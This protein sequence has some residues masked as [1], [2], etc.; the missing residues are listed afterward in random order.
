MDCESLTRTQGAT[1]Q[2]M[3]CEYLTATHRATQQSMDGGSL[4]AT[5][6]DMQQSVHCESLTP[7]QGA[8]Q[9]IIG[10]VSSTAQHSQRGTKSEL[11]ASTMPSRRPKS[12]PKA[13]SAL[14]SRWSPTTRNKMTIGCLSHAFSGAQKWADL[15]THI[16]ILSAPQHRGAK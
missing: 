11:A 9:Q 13:T 3:D 1:Q 5:Q 2:S 12:G 15:L 6:G 16:F 10:L 7:T 4:T 14:H 8:K